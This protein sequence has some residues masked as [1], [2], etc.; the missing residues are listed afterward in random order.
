MN[1]K[2]MMGFIFYLTAFSLQAEIIGKEISYQQ[3]DTVMKGYVAYDDSIKQQRPGVLVV[4]EWWGHNDYARQRARQ[5]AKL[6]YTALAVDMYGDGKQA[7]HPKN[8]GKFASAV[9]GNMP[10]AKARFEAALATLKAQPTVMADQVAAIGYCFGG[11]IVLNMARQGVDLKGVVSFHGSLATQNPASAGDIKAKVRVFNGAADPMVKAEHIAAFEQEMKNAGVDYKLVNYP[12]A[13]HAFTNPEADS[14][15]KKFQL[16][17]G[18]Q[19]HADEDSWAQMQSF[20]K[21]IF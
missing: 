8:A 3:G 17:L 10:L 7:D 15:A 14:N 5:L 21:S 1:R 20:F 4:H 13:K 18:Y 19:K 11:G 16:P 6:G 2:M 9:A 12:D